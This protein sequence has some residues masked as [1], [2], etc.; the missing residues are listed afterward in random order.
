MFL[1]TYRGFT[2][3]SVLNPAVMPRI[4][5]HWLVSHFIKVNGGFE[6]RRCRGGYVLDYGKRPLKEIM[7]DPPVLML[8]SR[9][10]DYS[11]P[12]FRAVFPKAVRLLRD[13]RVLVL[14]GY[15]LPEDDA[16][17][18]FILR[19]FAEEGEDGRSKIVLYVDPLA[20]KN[21]DQLEQ[22]LPS[23]D[24][25]Q[26]PEVLLYEGTFDRFAAEFCKLIPSH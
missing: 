18:R 12:Y 6:I 1:Y 17:I 5:D 16:L 11:D 7:N 13:T 22:V 8:P 25:T 3:T 20:A 4:H 26:V 9:E 19:Q 21:R 24:I 2:P 23:V 10:Q 15:S 14:V